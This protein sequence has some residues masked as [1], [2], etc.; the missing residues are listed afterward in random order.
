MTVKFTGPGLYDISSDD[1]HA[2]LLSPTPS[3]S[4]TIAKKLLAQSPLHAWTASPRLN[5]DYISKDSKTFDIGRA[6]HRAI[7]GKGEDFVA[8]PE[9]VLAANGAASTKEAKAFI[10]EAREA[11]LTPLKADEVAAVERMAQ[12]II[13]QLSANGIRISPHRSEVVAVAE[14]D[15]VM[16]RAMIDNA[17]IDPKLPLYDLKTCEDASPEACRAACRRYRYDLSAAHYTDV[18]KAVTNE[19]RDFLFV[20][21]EKTNPNAICIIGLDGQVMEAARVDAA[22]SREIWRICNRDNHWPGYPAG[23]H[24]VGYPE[25]HFAQIEE[26]RSIEADFKRRYGR[27]VIEAAAFVMEPENYKHAGE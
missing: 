18:W 21:I 23:V 24:R 25:F 1:Y 8:I 16:C 4:S 19:T 6:A 7:L 2:D 15:G 12:A 13:P 9:A 22:R 10:A 20:F 26:R 27:D 14:I 3:L 11:G 17:P 5:P